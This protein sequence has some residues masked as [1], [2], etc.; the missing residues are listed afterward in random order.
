M[1]CIGLPGWYGQSTGTGPGSGSSRPSVQ[2]LGQTSHTYSTR[3]AM[4]YGFG[5]VFAAA[6]AVDVAG[7][8]AAFSMTAIFA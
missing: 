4:A 3:C 5:S 1:I 2:C 8:A 7:L 6:G